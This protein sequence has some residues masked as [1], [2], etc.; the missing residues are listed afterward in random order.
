MVSEILAQGM[1][2]WMNMSNTVQQLSRFKDH[3]GALVKHASKNALLKQRFDQRLAEYS[4]FW[5]KLE[6]TCK[7]YCGEMKVGLEKMK[8][9][10]RNVENMSDSLDVTMR[11]S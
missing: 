5:D 7:D 2:F 6:R 9:F 8:E 3:T 11:G 1:A 10:I 4:E